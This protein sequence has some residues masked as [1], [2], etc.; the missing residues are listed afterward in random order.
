MKVWGRVLRLERRRRS[1]KTW[2]EQE[3]RRFR[4]FGSMLSLFAFH[5]LIHG[6]AGSDDT[7]MGW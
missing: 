6:V 1:N 4:S 3:Q 5:D 7:L 2:N